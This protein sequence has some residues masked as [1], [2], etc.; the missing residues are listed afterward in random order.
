MLREI[1]RLE[2][3]GGC[4][5]QI[6]LMGAARPY[7]GQVTCQGEDVPPTEDTLKEIVE[8]IVEIV[9]ALEICRRSPKTYLI[10]FRCTAYPAVEAC[11]LARL[12]CMWL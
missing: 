1:E 5:T 3:D 10:N 9:K 11:L 4:C 6:V 7:I 12:R 8:E 2:D